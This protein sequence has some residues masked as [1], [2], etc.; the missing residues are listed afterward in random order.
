[1]LVVIVAVVLVVAVV[2]PGVAVMVLSRLSVLAR[3]DVAVIVVVM[4]VAEQ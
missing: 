3:R 1:M 4:L 2:V